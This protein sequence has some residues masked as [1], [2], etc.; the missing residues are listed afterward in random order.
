MNM[1]NP[2]TLPL[3][4]AGIQQLL[5][6]FVTVILDGKRLDP[7]PFTAGRAADFDLRV[8]QHL[9]GD[10][11]P[12]PRQEI[13]FSINDFRYAKRA[14]SGLIALYCRE[15]INP[16]FLQKRTNCFHIASVFI[17][18]IFVVFLI[19]CRRMRRVVQGGRLGLVHASV[20]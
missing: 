8:R 18:R 15:I 7:N 16:A 9:L 6:H 3:D 20:A 5:P 13:E 4:A 12:L 11:L 17:M 14:H 2:I 1:E 19:Y 10:F